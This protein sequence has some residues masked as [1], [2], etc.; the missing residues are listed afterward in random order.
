MSGIVHDRG[1]DDR[2]DDREHG[3]RRPDPRH[4]PA[5]PSPAGCGDDRREPET[6]AHHDPGA[7]EE[8]RTARVGDS[9]TVEDLD[10]TPLEVTLVGIE[11]PVTSDNQFIQPD[12]GNRFV[13]VRLRI[14]NQGDAPYDDPPSNGAAVVD[15][16]DVEWDGNVFEA[17]EPSL[18]TVTIAPGDSREGWI[19]FEVGTAPLRTFQWATDSGFG[20]TGGVATPVTRAGG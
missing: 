20:N 6:R 7:P 10:G 3:R 17:K 12:A 14:R 13:G 18:G 4:D 5:A 8:A 16:Q 9:I 11:D 2:E 1:T 19:S 15:G